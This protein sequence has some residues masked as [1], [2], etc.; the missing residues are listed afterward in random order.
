MI[1]SRVSDSSKSKRVF[2]R[3][4]SIIL[5]LYGIY[6]FLAQTFFKGEWYINR[7]LIALFFVLWA[8]EYYMREKKTEI[9]DAVVYAGI[10]IFAII[11]VLAWN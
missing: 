4:Y 7:F 1:M 9:P 5:T 8:G 10:F 3:I 2:K 11:D 6:W